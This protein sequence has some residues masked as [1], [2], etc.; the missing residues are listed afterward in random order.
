MNVYQFRFPPVGSKLWDA[1]RHVLFPD[2]SLHV[3]LEA[4][5]PEQGTCHYNDV[6]GCI[7]YQ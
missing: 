6:S 2:L 7:T 1:R 5:K 4:T 3:E